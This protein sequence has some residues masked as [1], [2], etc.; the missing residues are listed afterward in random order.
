MIDNLEKNYKRMG[1][2]FESINSL[3]DYKYIYVF[4]VEIPVFQNLSFN[5]GNPKL[6]IKSIEQKE[7][8]KILFIDVNLKK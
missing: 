2:L 1:I 7:N 4:N 6:H 3:K 8:K 5:H